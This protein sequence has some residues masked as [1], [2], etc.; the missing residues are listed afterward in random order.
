MFDIGMWE[1]MVVGVVA[2]IVVGPK[3]LPKMFR[4]LGQVT[5][6]IRG[7]AREFQTTMNA[8]ASESGLDDMAKD[9]RR[10]TDVTKDLRKMTSPRKMGLDALK[11]AAAPAEKWTPKQGQEPA[12]ETERLAQQRLQEQRDRAEAATARADARAAAEAAEADATAALSEEDLPRA[13]ARTGT[14]DT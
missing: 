14:S 10:A 7:L 8:A 9:L 2:L 11:D 1:L 13:E 5:G 12:N 6:R 4:T 3:D